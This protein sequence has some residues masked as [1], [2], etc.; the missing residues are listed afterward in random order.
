MLWGSQ[1]TKA[2]SIPACGILPQLYPSSNPKLG[3]SGGVIPCDCQG[4]S[5]H[6][7]PCSTIRPDETQEDGRR[8]EE[9][10]GRRGE[11][12]GEP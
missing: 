1:I 12:K 11:E 3:N 4:N 10:K 2:V 6:L 8:G 9:A 7:M 5:E